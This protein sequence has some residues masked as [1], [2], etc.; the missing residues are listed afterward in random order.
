MRVWVEVGGKWRASVE[1]ARPGP[2]ELSVPVEES[3]SAEP[4]LIE[5]R[6]SRSFRWGTDPRALG[7]VVHEL[8]F[9]GE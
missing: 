2:F 9:E 8:G 7:A 5:L 6:T 3:A 1:L 4:L